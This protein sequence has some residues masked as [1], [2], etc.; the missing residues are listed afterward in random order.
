MPKELRP[1]QHLHHPYK[2]STS[3]KERKPCGNC[4][5]AKYA[6]R[7]EH[8]TDH[9]LIGEYVDQI[10]PYCPCGD[11]ADICPEYEIF[12]T[13]MHRFRHIPV[14]DYFCSRTNVDFEHLS[15]LEQRSKHSHQEQRSKHSRKKSVDKNASCEDQ[16]SKCSPRETSFDKK[17]SCEEPECTPCKV[18]EEEEGEINRTDE[19][20]EQLINQLQEVKNALA[21]QNQFL[22]QQQ[23]L[24]YYYQPFSNHVLSPDFPSQ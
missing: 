19:L 9:I 21:Y 16:R 8:L 7:D 15:M 4:H 11:K 1:F 18:S 3:K 12:L 2:T 13:C 23:D 5:F 24:R 20:L 14:K 10:W 17:D 22:Q 6:N